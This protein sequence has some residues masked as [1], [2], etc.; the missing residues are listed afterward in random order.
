MSS[1]SILV[2]RGPDAQIDP[3]LLSIHED[4][5]VVS[6]QSCGD[7]ETVKMKATAWLNGHT[8]VESDEEAEE[9]TTGGF[10]DVAMGFTI[11]ET[12]IADG[13]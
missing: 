2:S 12:E 13:D 5:E 1:T 4:E 10:G 6:L 9:F 7:D 8:G 3:L 11:D